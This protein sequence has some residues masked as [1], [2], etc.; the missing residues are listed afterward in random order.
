M[1]RLEIEKEK[2]R[3]ARR[4]RIR[5]MIQN[6]ERMV[7]DDSHMD[8]PEFYKEAYEYCKKKGLMKEK[9]TYETL[10]DGLK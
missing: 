7:A 2:E 8:T 9:I 3:R 4:K 10:K 6:I 1:N 5:K